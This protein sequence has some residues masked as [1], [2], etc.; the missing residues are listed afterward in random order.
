VSA[1]LEVEELEGL[2]NPCAE[3][4]VL[5]RQALRGGGREA[6]GLRKRAKGASEE[7]ERAK[8]EREEI[9]RAEKQSERRKRGKMRSEGGRSY[10]VETT[11]GDTLREGPF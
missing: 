1:G 4:G 8:K 10:D 7:W 9:E 5:V 3:T 11:A 6:S 2:V